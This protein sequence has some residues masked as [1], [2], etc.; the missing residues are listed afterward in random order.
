MVIRRASTT[1]T[2]P[3]NTTAYAAKDGIS[4]AT[5]S[6]AAISIQAEGGGYIVGAKIVTN[7]ASITPRLRVHLYRS[8]PTQIADNA[9][10][11]AVLY[12]DAGNY[13]GFIDLGP[14]NTEGSGADSSY[15]EDNTLRHPYVGDTLNMIWETLDAFTP[16]SAQEFT[17]IFLYDRG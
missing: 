15:A 6:P 12:A 4:D 14:L 9:A 5:S 16:A 8:A 10:V 17:L 2:R 3:A 13:L 11:T 7:K 1:L